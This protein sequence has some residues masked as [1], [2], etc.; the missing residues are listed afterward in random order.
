MIRPLNTSL[1]LLL[2]LTL[3]ALPAAP[4]LARP[5]DGD[6]AVGRIVTLDGELRLRRAD[7]GTI[8]LDD[9]R[10]TQRAPVLEGDR[11]RSGP[12]SRIDIALGADRLRLDENSVVTVV[13]LDARHVDL[14]LERGRIAVL[15][16]GDDDPARWR[17]RSSVGA[18]LPLGP[19]LF[20][21]DAPE[22]E[23]GRAGASATAW[24][25]AM[26]IET[27]EDT[28]QLP[29]GRRAEPDGRGGWRLGL[30]QAD[31]FARWAMSE[32]GDSR[33]TGRALAR[34]PVDLPPDLEG[35]DQ[36][37]RNGRWEQS[38]E[39]GWLWVPRVGLSWEPF[40]QG[41]WRRTDSGWIW[42]DDAPWGVATYRHGRW[43]RWDGRW[44]WMP[45]PPVRYV[46]PV[47]PIAPVPEVVVPPRVVV[48]P[49]PPPMVIETRPAPPVREVA[50]PVTVVRPWAPE[51]PRWNAPV[52]PPVR[53]APPRPDRRAHEEPQA[54]QAPATPAGPP[55]ELRRSRR[56]L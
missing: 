6:E 8:E 39:W 29:P 50:P 48:R 36:L 52:E 33:G 32:G 27:D 3:L 19:G 2:G 24:R 17:I 56:A 49:A 22:D 53:Q 1:A 43:L 42:V 26:R 51:T 18:H 31:R 35:A 55:D 30:P 11:L 4:V 16:R 47:A 15:L 23:R 12:G 10:S 25:S 5:G 38:T 41:L 14:W 40:H 9:R 46:E 44:A 45:G 28:L 21:V 54:P 20:R 37:D 13:R 7:A 34:A